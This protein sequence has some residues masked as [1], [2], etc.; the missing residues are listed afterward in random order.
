VTRHVSVLLAA[1]LGLAGCRSPRARP[2]DRLRIGF[3]P[4]VTHAAALIA[5]ERDAWRALPVPVETKAFAAGPEAMEALFAG[6]L[7]ACFIGP[8]P[9]VNGYLRSGGQAIVIVAGAAANGAGFVVGRDSGITS[10]ESLHGKRLAAPQ[11]GNTQDVALRIYLLKHGLRSREL[12]G[13]VQVM[14]IA[15]PDI[16]TLLRLG[17]L[18]GAWVPEPWVARLVEEAGARL[19]VD[20]RDLWPGRRFPSAVLVVTRALADARPELVRALVALHVENV[21]WALAH[22]DEARAL[23]DAGIFKAAHKRLAPKVLAR[24]YANVALTW[25]PMPD[26]LAQIVADGRRLDYL[27]QA[28][29]ARAAVDLSYLD[30]ALQKNNAALQ[31]ND[32]AVEHD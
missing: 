30:A 9:A 7:D 15:N 17:R 21:R 24:A 18:D 11:L 3:F 1:A 10:P 19:F 26:A 16:L 20:E 31:T 12:G 4:T 27:P 2:G 29:D 13:D 28:G 25:D 14:P 22:P 32:A 8:M 6:A 5:D 23:V